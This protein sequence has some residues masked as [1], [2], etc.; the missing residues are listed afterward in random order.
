[1]RFNCRSDL[2]P[3]WCVDPDTAIFYLELCDGWTAHKFWHPRRARFPFCA[4][5]APDQFRKARGDKRGRVALT[6][7][8]NRCTQELRHAMQDLHSAIFGVAAQTNHCGDVEI[9][10]PERLGQS[11]GGPELFLAR[12][13]G[14]R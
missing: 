10:F 2:R 1:M 4:A 11:V 3:T 7:A 6:I 14:P 12:N 13:A 5:G 9:E 8:F